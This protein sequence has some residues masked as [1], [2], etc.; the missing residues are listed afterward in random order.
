MCGTDTRGGGEVGR[1]AQ[2]RPRKEALYLVTKASSQLWP[3]GAWEL[4]VPLPIL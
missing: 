4:R 3:H 2:V 1:A